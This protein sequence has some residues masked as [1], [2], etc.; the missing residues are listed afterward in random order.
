MH[1]YDDTVERVPFRL[2]QVFCGTRFPEGTRARA[3]G[4]KERGKGEVAA[5][6]RHDL[7]TTERLERQKPWAV[8]TSP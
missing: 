7:R 8:D 6:A 3:A 5:R 4:E 1:T 2:H